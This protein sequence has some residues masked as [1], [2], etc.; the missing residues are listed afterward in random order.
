MRLSDESHSHVEQFFRAHRGDPGLVLPRIRLHGGRCARLLMLASAGMG[1]M[2]LG[3]HV[4]VSP[5]LFRKDTSG[6]LTLP[7]WLVVHEA[8]HVLQ[9]AERGFVRFLAG[10]LH[11]YWRALRESGR[12]DVRA[13]TA[14]YLSLEEEREA[15]MAEDAYASQSDARHSPEP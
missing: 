8:A 1:A 12:W 11:G 9:Y 5:G 15:R 7:G 2:T 14:A 10:Y 6:R 4:F 13:R 3:R